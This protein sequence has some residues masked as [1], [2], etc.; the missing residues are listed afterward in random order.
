LLQALRECAPSSSISHDP[1]LCESF[2]IGNK[3]GCEHGGGKWCGRHIPA[4]AFGA[5]RVC[6]TPH[7]TD[8]LVVVLRSWSHARDHARPQVYNCSSSASSALH[9]RSVRWTLRLSWASAALFMASIVTIP[10]HVLPSSC[11][12]R[13]PLQAN[14]PPDK[15]FLVIYGQ[16]EPF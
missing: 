7:S 2:V 4:F 6:N 15:R 11:G 12:G 13:R 1:P 16:S 5:I 3:A 9:L 10:R 8:S 14:H